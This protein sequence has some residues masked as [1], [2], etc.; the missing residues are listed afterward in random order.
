MMK[1]IDDA[2][3]DGVDV[4]SFSIGGPLEIPGMLHA[5]ANDITVV[6]S[7]GNGGPTA[8][9]VHNSCSPPWLLAVAATTI[10]RLFPTDITLGNNQRIVGQSLYV[11]TEEG[12]DHFYEVLPYFGIECDP[13]YINNTDVMG[14]VIFC[15]TPSNLSPSNNI[16]AIVNLLLSKGGKGF[17]FSQK[18]TDL[19]NRW[20]V[21]SK[22]I[23]VIA[24]DLEVAYQI[25]Q[26]CI[27]TD[28]PKAKIS[29]THTTIGSVVPA[30]NVAAFS[31][32]GPSP[33]YPGVL[34]PDIAAPGVNILA[35]APQIAYYKD[36]G[37]LYHFGSGTS[38]ACPHV[39]GVVALLKSI[40][41]DWSPAALKSALM[42]TALSTDNTELPIQ[43]DGNLAKIGNPFDYGAG[44][45]NPSK[46]DDP[47]L[48]YDIDP[49]DYLK[50]FYCMGGL[51]ANDN[52]T[53]SS[54]SVAD[55]NLPSIAI[56]NLKTSETVMRT[57]TNVDQPD[58]V[59][60]ALFQPP[61][62]V[63]MSIEPSVLM[64]SKERKV[65]SFEVTF[66]AMRKI[67]GDYT[68]GSLT[69]HDGGSHWVRIP[70]AVRIV[71]EDFYSTIS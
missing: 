41:S 4:I 48:I 11:A 46:A 9:T 15:I 21:T 53:I 40:H 23:P 19:L 38:M 7:A 2:I 29:S 45:V 14:N 58:A 16:A 10:D 32:R 28:T 37:V 1:A 36:L 61:P 50:F 25:L 69:W 70:I 65:Q 44:F 30:P 34:K 56:P 52:C 60:R 57:V 33:I 3:H 39:S 42:T 66:K 43:A 24:V 64:F 55:L 13:D 67:Q 18:N 54:A 68:F 35:A 51:G 26:Y 62:G 6:C 20:E 47:G 5:V 49:S 71:I 59:Y 8:Q 17:I 63:E 12:T 27:S 22:L 31:S